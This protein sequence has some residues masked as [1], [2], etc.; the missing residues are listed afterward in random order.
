MSRH[1]ERETVF[2]LL[3]EYTFYEGADP[4]T[5]LSSREVANETEYSEYVRITF[6]NTLSSLPEIDGQITE[7]AHGWKVGRMSKVTR[8][9]LRLAV[10][11]MLFTDTPPKAVI[12][13]AVELSK[14]YD[15]GKAPSFINGILNNIA[16]S[17]GKIADPENNE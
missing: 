8:S 15:D 1:S 11:E 2:T 16:R 17:K 4:V 5:F 10:Y 3:F 6:I 14:E 12:N 7:F 9:I 13:E